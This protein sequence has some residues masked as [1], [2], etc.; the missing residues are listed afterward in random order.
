MIRVAVALAVVGLVVACGG[1]VSDDADQTLRLPLTIDELRAKQFNT[2]LEYAED[3]DDGP[4]FDAHLVRYEIDEL[5]LYALVAVPDSEPPASGFPVIVANHGYVPDPR[6]YGITRDGRDSRPGDY[7]RPVPEIFTTRG[8]LVVMPDFRGHNR[9]DGYKYVHPDVDIAIAYYAEDVVALLSALGDL[10]Q[11]DIDKVHMWSHSMG[12]P[13]S[14]RA[15]LATD[16]VKSASFWSPMNVS[17]LLPHLGDANV[18]MIIHHAVG[19]TS[20][21]HN[22]SKSFAVALQAAGIL[23]EFHSYES[24]E[25]FFGEDIRDVAADR[26]TA[27]FSAER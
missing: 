21:E 22:N 6:K 20:T 19:D 17:D 13:V 7:Y 25:H 15:M 5:V 27:F 11:V 1:P 9:S 24:D 4:G 8:F 10:E 12:G 23:H 18:P 3:V 26:D 2:S 14:L 16:V